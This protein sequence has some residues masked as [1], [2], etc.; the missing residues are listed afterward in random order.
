MPRPRSLSDHVIMDSLKC[1]LGTQSHHPVTLVLTSGLKWLSE[2][3][4]SLGEVA[5]GLSGSQGELLGL[6]RLVTTLPDT[7][8]KERWASSLAGGW[9][10]KMISIID[11][12]HCQLGKEVGTGAE[13]LEKSHRAEMVGEPAG[14]LKSNQLLWS[15]PVHLDGS[16]GKWN[17]PWASGRQKTGAKFS[18]VSVGKMEKG[19]QRP[20]YFSRFALTLG[21][22]AVWWKVS[23]SPHVLLQYGKCAH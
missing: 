17:R 6:S 22:Q 3:L 20:G 11:P 23:F 14:Q 1:P 12:E 4:A 5:R 16:P 8:E 18:H 21:L 9:G 13:T 10:E 2:S 7:L 15:Q 19:V